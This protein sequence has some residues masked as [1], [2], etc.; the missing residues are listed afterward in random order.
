MLTN[1]KTIV[2]LSILLMGLA[3]AAVATGMMIRRA[4][5]VYVPADIGNMIINNDEGEKHIVAGL[6]GSE[7]TIV[8][9]GEPYIESGAYAVDDRTG[10]VRSYKVKGSVNTSKTGTYE[11]I[12]VFKNRGAI[13]SIT[14][15]VHVIDGFR[16][17][18]NKTGV[19][20]LMYHYLYDK[21]LPKTKFP[22]NYI[23]VQDMERQ[24]AYLNSEGYYYP[25]YAE[26][27]AYIENRISL[28][29]KSV[30]LTFDDGD[31][32]FFKYGIPVLEKYKVPAT[33]FLIGKALNGDETIIRHRS[34][35]VCYESHSFDMHKGGGNVGM[36]G[37]ISAMTEKEI[38]EDLE[39]SIRII[40][41]DDA[42]AYPYGDVTADGRDAVSKVG[43]Y[44]A[45]TTKF[46]KVCRG[47]DF[48]ALPR[49]RIREQEPLE[50]LIE[51][52]K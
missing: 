47:D 18:W 10:P 44:C 5:P 29:E 40:D 31:S 2:I 21:K 30:I 23:K 49:V 7:N 19:P 6:K 14:R 9:A 26:L 27:R 16:L 24:L 45:F 43:F 3:A 50:K 25:S 46:G 8:K 34:P 41:N 35:Y 51:N 33:S 48:T 42:F 11:V 28:P 36:G 39:K 1:K 32:S 20:V 38:I 13:K 15:K 12:Y 4:E 22:G 37:V 17:K 52:I